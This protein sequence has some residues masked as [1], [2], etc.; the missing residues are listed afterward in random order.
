MYST[1]YDWRRVEQKDKEKVPMCM[2][3]DEERN[4]ITPAFQTV[5]T[6]MLPKV[7][8]CIMKSG[9]IYVKRKL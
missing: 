1:V 3:K 2:I 7:V 5:S 9:T 8:G 4:K 6:K